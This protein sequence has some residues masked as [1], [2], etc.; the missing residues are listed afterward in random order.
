MLLSASIRIWE[1]SLMLSIWYFWIC[2]DLMHA[3]FPILLGIPWHYI[4]DY[5]MML[6]QFFVIRCHIKKANICEF[7]QR[8]ICLTYYC[9]YFHMISHIIICSA[10][11][12]FAHIFTLLHTQLHI[13]FEYF[14]KKWCNK[15]IIMNAILPNL[16]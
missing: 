16:S 5:I 15:V 1:T 8:L 14:F 2:I 7:F 4:I 12:F 3:R 6:V 9:A 11:Y 13:I 10:W